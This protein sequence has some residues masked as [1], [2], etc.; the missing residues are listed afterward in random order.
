[1]LPRKAAVPA[2]EHTA[3]DA[4]LSSSVVFSPRRVNI[5]VADIKTLVPRL[6]HQAVNATAAMVC[7]TQIL[8]A[9][10][11][12]QLKNGQS[13]APAATWAILCHDG[14]SKSKK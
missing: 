4:Y 11:Q 9:H 12:L 8:S 5:A 14:A 3:E 6:V 1:M 2:R 7:P 10:D 13:I